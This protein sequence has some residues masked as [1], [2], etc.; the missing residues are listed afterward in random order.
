MALGVVSV[1][2]VLLAIM[3]ASSPS[4]LRYDE[5]YHLRVA[6]MVRESGWRAAMS[7]PDSQSAAGPLFAAVHLALSPLTGRQAP[8][9][10]WVNFVCLVAVILLLA[11]QT[12][13][14]SWE[15]RCTAAASILSVPF[16]WPTSGMA[17]TELPA[18]VVFTL[19]VLAFLRVL[20]LPDGA[21]TRLIAWASVAGLCLGVAI[22]GRQTYLVA[23]PVILAMVFWLP[24][25]WPIFAVTVALSL[26]T[27]GWLFVLWGGLV[28]PSA[29]RV[30]SGFR[31]DHGVL[32]LSY[33]G[34]ATLLLNPRWMKPRNRAVLVG[35]LA[36]GVLLACLAR[37]YANPPARSLLVQMFD[38]RVA[39]LAGF[40]IG[41]GLA[42]IG[43][44]WVWNTLQEAWREREHPA[45]SFLFLI[46]FALVAAPMKVSHLF[47]SRYVVGLLGVLFI[48][49]WLPGEQR[50]WWVLRMVS[51]C[52]IGA[53]TLWTYFR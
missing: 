4:R 12:S 30:S 21:S 27:C 36:A 42:G 28:P 25:R 49:V 52:S 50:G 47:S 26:V 24:Q 34:G 22:L 16:L 1:C 3:I 23:L 6:E 20:Y 45:R 14:R 31:L 33:V 51:G 2:L 40:V 7:S 38:E 17:L 44:V 19:F 15:V 37:D 18:L 53:A 43:M 5:P 29:Q 35:S 32:S 13:G 41:L 46:L 39:L 8:A 48:V 9:V 11:S 10:R